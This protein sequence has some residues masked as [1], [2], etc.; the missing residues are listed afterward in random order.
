MNQTLF[1]APISD[2][3]CEVR[4]SIFDPFHFNVCCLKFIGMENEQ[5][6]CALAD[7]LCVSAVC[8]L[9][10]IITDMKANLTL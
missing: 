7:I 8:S 6:M 1:P 9:Y 3:F 10:V 2:A 4:K 5:P